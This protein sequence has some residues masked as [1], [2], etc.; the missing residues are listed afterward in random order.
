[1]ATEIQAK[2]HRCK[3]TKTTRPTRTSL[4][5]SCKNPR[6]LTDTHAEGGAFGGGASRVEAGSKVRRRRYAQ[7]GGL[8]V[9]RVLLLRGRGGPGPD[10]GGSPLREQRQGEA[11]ANRAGVPHLARPWRQPR[12]TLCLQL[13]GSSAAWTLLSGPGSRP[14]GSLSVPACRLPG[15]S[16][17]GLGPAESSCAPYPPLEPGL[18]ASWAGEPQ[19]GGYCCW[20]LGAVGRDVPGRGSCGTKKRGPSRN[21]LSEIWVGGLRREA[22]TLHKGSWSAKEFGPK[23]VVTLKGLNQEDDILFYYRVLKFSVEKIRK[24]M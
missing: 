22:R 15:R 2:L 7:D 14:G 20:I 21:F 9:R 5:N 1:M 18:S 10:R 13:R 3:S 24:C 4:K 19:A 16:R 6:G 23:P 11:A 17:G 8:H 12:G